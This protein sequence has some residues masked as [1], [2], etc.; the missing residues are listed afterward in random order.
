MSIFSIIGAFL[1]NN[2]ASAHNLVVDGNY[3]MEK[4]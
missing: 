1:A 2:L 3:I 4:K